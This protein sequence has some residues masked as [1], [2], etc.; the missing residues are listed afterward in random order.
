MLRVALVA[1][2][3]W[4]LVNFQLPL[5][6]ALRARGDE[7]VF[8]CP[9]GRHVDALH[10]ADFQWLPWRIERRS[11]NPLKESAALLRLIRLYRKVRPD[12]AHHFTIKPAIYG[13]IAARSMGVPLVFNAFLGLGYV[14]S[15][16]PG[17][18]GLRRSLVPLM[19]RVL[20]MPVGPIVLENEQDRRAFQSHGIAPRER[21]TVIPASGG[22]GVDTERFRPAPEGQTERATRDLVV[23]F[24]GRLLEDK[25]IAEYVEAARALR[26][27]VEGVQ[28]W[29][30][31]EPDPGN[32]ACIDHERLRSW[33]AEG[34][35]RFL[36][37][38]REMDQLLREVD[39]AVLPS[40]H[41]GLPR[42][43][44]E[45]AA[46]G[47]PVVATDIEGCR[48]VVRHEKNGLLV[49]PR[50]PEQLA[51]AIGRLLQHSDE[52]SRM[53]ADGRKFVRCNFSETRVVGRYI[54]LYDSW[55]KRIFATNERPA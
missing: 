54:E 12:V 14:F 8:I 20:A 47:L 33:E 7:V 11:L 18:G 9:F 38:C 31:G 15:D 36:G 43:L 22:S 27:Q 35:V 52:R 37:F 46:S 17:S 5:A 1:H 10:A 48:L 39:I 13:S 29:V 42:F 16:A 50:D 21:L 2:W 55:T 51:G 25:G 53:G 40:Y 3:D 32:P 44:M 45:A 19:R 26:R 49:R 34:V 23:L 30:A 28:F 24:A 6:R 41:E 4:V